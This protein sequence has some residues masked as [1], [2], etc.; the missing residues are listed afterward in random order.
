MAYRSM[1]SGVF[2]LLAA[3]TLTGCGG[4][5]DIGAAKRE[6][7]FP[8]S[9]VVLYNGQPVEGAI[10][11]FE[12]LTPEK[13]GATARTNAQGQFTLTTYKAGDGAVAGRFIAAVSKATIEGE[14]TSYSNVDS[15]NYGKVPPPAALGKVKYH[16]PEKYGKTDSSQLGAEIT[17]AG[18]TEIKLELVDG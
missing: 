6:A 3:L 13:P 1:C 5:D 10:V 15:P 2:I 7:T 4:G 16:V 18:N 9:G 14:D 12:C 8:A 11:V 17:S